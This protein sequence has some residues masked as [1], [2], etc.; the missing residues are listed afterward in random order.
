MA[1]HTR[2]SVAENRRFILEVSLAEFADGLDM[3]VEGKR[4]LILGLSLELLCEYWYFHGE[5]ERETGYR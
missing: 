4:E 1:A 3:R 5:T 2:V